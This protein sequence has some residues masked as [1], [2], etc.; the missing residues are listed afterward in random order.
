MTIKIPDSAIPYIKLQRTGHKDVS[1]YIKELYE[2]FLII[3]DFIP[4]NIR[5][6]IDIGCGICGIDILINNCSDVAMF[7]LIDGDI[8]NTPTYGFNDKSSFYNSFDAA[9]EMLRIN[10]ITEEQYMLSCASNYKELPKYGY[11]FDLVLSLLSCGYPPRA[12]FQRLLNSC[13]SA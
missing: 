8:N 1:E 4:D 2:E 7:D 6:I 13:K 3:E 9:R 10:N 5:H 12:P 11:K